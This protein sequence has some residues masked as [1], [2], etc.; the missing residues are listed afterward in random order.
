MQAMLKK[1]L[2][3]Q[4]QGVEEDV[5]KGGDETK[6]RPK[7]DGFMGMMMKAG[8]D[9][10]AQKAFPVFWLVCVSMATFE[11]IMDLRRTSY[12][13]VPTGSVFFEIGVPLSLA[14]F[15]WV[16]FSDPGKLP[17]RAKGHSGVEEIMKALDSSLP[18]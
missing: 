10:T 1:L 8:H 14:F 11:Y 7:K 9:K 15:F 18:E 12:E 17:A 13:V 16:A 2:T 6:A 4:P 3:K 5:E